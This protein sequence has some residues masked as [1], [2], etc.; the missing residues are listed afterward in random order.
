MKRIHTLQTLAGLVLAAFLTPASAVTIDFEGIGDATPV[1]ATYSGVGLT[2]TN[3]TA[4][5]SGVSLNEF[6]FP[7]ASGLSVAIDDGGPISGVFASPVTLLSVLATYTEALTLLGF[8]AGGVQVA[9]ATSAFAQNFASSGNPPN[10]LL[11]IGSA[12]GIKSFTLQGAALGNSFTID[13]LTFTPTNGTS[14]PDSAP[15]SSGLAVLL[16]GLFVTA[17]RFTLR[18]SARR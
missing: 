11:Q 18:S 3:A 14:V 16:I 9:S 2:L 6:E 5:T 1:G 15:L 12:G 8:N 17:R 13:N 7:P 10:E 4:L